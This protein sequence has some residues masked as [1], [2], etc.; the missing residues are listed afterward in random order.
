MRPGRRTHRL[1]KVYRR[2]PGGN[3]S[4][5]FKLKRPKKA[6]CAICGAKLAGVPNETPVN[7]RR[8]AK[9]KKRPERKFGGVLCHKCAE[10]VIKYK[11]RVDSGQISI[12]DVHYAYKKYV[13]QLK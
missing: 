10:K 3:N 1:R 7:M 13:E 9:T 11:A 6:T 12:S 4:I 8:M 2:T 5:L